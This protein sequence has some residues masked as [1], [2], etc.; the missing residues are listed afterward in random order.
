MTLNAAQE[1]HGYEKKF[2]RIRLTNI[3]TR[4][5]IPAYHVIRS[6]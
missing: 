3:K 4:F 2:S 6:Y 5:Q 1:F